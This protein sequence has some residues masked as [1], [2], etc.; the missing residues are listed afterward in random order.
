[1]AGS[2]R[3]SWPAVLAAGP[4]KKGAVFSAPPLGL[5][6]AGFGAAAERMEG[7]G[8][9]AAAVGNRHGIGA[10]QFGEV[11]N[12]SAGNRF[13]KRLQQAGVAVWRCGGG[14]AGVAPRRGGAP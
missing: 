5:R 11:G 9:A 12:V 13:A 6:G 7:R 8:L 4:L 10:Q 3:M 2:T 14:G 1:M